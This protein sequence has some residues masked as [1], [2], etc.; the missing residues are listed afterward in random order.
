MP[1]SGI[2]HATRARIRRR[3]IQSRL[4]PSVI[5]PARRSFSEEGHLIQDLVF[6]KGQEALKIELQLERL[7]RV[8]FAMEEYLIGKTYNPP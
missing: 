8:V 3:G 4:H 1:V 7:F 2:Q 5:L 6:L